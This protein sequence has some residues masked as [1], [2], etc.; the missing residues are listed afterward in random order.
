[1]R[2]GVLVFAVLLFFAQPLFAEFSKTIHFSCP[3]WKPMLY[4]EGGKIKG[5]YTEFLG[6][7]FEKNM[8]IK[9]KYDIIP[10]KRAQIYVEKGDADLILTVPTKKRLTF[11]IKNEKPIY[12]M[13]LH[14]YT[15]KNHKQ[16]RQIRQIKLAKDILKLDLIPVTNLGNG[17]HKQH[18]DSYGVNTYYVPREDN[19]VRVL[20]SKRADIMIDAV[21]P[22]NYKIKQYGL[23]SKLELTNARF[24]PLNF[25]ILMSKKSKYV[26]YMPQIN[27][28]VNKLTKNG[29]LQNITQKYKKLK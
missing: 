19:I 26:K 12:Q 9:V 7:I 10:W 27:R 6:A 21:I 4:S 29:T 18:I 20:A 25:H 15:Y 8:S 14:I 11:S 24:G 28:V 2:I 13:Y 23:V 3:E 22:T 17:W 16:I 1:M 5:M